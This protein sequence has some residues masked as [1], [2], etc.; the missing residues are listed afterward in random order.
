MGWLGDLLQ[1]FMF[2]DERRAR[3]EQSRLAALADARERERLESER[4]QAALDTVERLRD[5]LKYRI[6][7]EGDPATKQMLVGRLAATEETFTQLLTDQ[8]FGDARA[9]YFFT[10][11]LRTLVPRE[12][13]SEIQLDDPIRETAVLVEQAGEA[14]GATPVDAEGHLLR[15]NALYLLSQQLEGVGIVQALADAISAYDQALQ[16]YTREAL[17][18][19]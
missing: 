1:L 17:P 6:G 19:D 4:R 10:E 3:A 16:V 13:S 7:V 2:R 5:N 8:A 11:N 9:R 15:G 18:Q 12:I 14:T